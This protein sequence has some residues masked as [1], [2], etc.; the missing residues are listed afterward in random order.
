VRDGQFQTQELGAPAHNRLVQHQC[1]GKIRLR[2]GERMANHTRTRPTPPFPWLR[3]DRE[4][5][6][7]DRVRG[8]G[9]ARICP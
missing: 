2:P 7:G 4:Q 8:E 5:R 6:C 3:F 9:L 1:L